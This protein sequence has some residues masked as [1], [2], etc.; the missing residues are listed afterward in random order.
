MVSPF[1]INYVRGS[2]PRC[3][4]DGEVTPVLQVRV[5]SLIVPGYCTNGQFVMLPS[6][7]LP[8]RI[9]SLRPS[10]SGGQGQRPVTLKLQSFKKLRTRAN[11]F[12]LDFT[13]WEW[14]KVY[15]T[16]CAFLNKQ[17]ET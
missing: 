11:K 2:Y 1:Y 3:P 14:G 16:Q 7:M 17:V 10:I 5:I 13:A 9:K 12:S 8:S 4:E 15:I 6:S